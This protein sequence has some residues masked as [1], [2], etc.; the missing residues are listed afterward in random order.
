MILRPNNAKE[1]SI[2]IHWPFCVSKCPYCDFNSHTFEKID[3]SSWEKAY[4]EDLEKFSYLFQG[5]N[6]NSIFFGGGTPSLMPPSIAASI[7]SKISQIAYITQDTEITLEANPSSVESSKFE[8]FK[9]AGVNRISIGI[10]SFNDKNLKFLGRKHSGK[11][12]LGALEVAGKYF[13]NYSFDL[14][15]GLPDQTLDNWHKELEFALNFAS[16]HISLYQLT[17]EKGTPFYSMHKRKE[18][19]LPDQEVAANLYDLTNNMLE[20]RGFELYEISSYAQKGF[21]SKHNL[22]YWQYGDYLGIGP[23]AHSRLSFLDEGI[24]RMQAAEMIYKPADWLKANKRLR[25]VEVLSQQDIAKEIIMMG[26]R[27]IKG[28]ND[29]VLEKF[30]GKRFEQIIDKPFLQKLIGAKLLECDNAATRLSD[31]GIKL[32]SKIITEIFDHFLI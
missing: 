20:A 11:E 6:I 19:V 7:I 18:F 17:I 16:K 15:Y 32:H 21:E 31:R 29:D 13:D 23:G 1:I 30:T 27:L 9:Q 28:M 26:L 3:Y 8:G 4:L 10:Q 12:A 24:N 14:I 5:K 25:N 22:N 2:Y